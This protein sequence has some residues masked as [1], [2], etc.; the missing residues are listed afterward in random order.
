[1]QPVQL[2]L[3]PETCP[4]PSATLT[5]SPSPNRPGMT[6]GPLS[7]LAATP[8]MSPPLL[9]PLLPEGPVAAAVG[10]MGRL[11]AEA[12]THATTDRREAGDE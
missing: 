10:L 4:A 1:M 12:V 8:M 3:L 9:P 11:I 6:T 7:D 5:S 2:S